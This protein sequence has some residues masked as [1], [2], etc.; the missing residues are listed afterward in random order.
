MSAYCS[1]SALYALDDDGSLIAMTH[2][3]NQKDA[4]LNELQNYQ[5]MKEQGREFFANKAN[6]FTERFW[7]IQQLDECE[8]SKNVR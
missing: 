1:F 7:K 2:R 4:L 5:Q 3:E 8:C 6:Q